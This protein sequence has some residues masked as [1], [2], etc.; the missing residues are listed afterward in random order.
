MDVLTRERAK[1]ALPFAGAYQ[2]LDFPLSNLAHSGITD[3]WLSVQYHASTLEEQAANGRPWDLD[4]TRGGL[5]LLVPQ[6]GTG[7][8]DEEGFARGNADL[9][10]RIRDEITA[11]GPDVLLVLSA[12]HVYRYDYNDLLDAHAGAGATCT[13]LTTE[14]PL[15]EASNHAVVEVDA[16]GRVTAFADKPADPSSGVVATEVFAYRPDA[17]VATLEDL[18]RELSAT[19]DGPEHDTGLGD[20]G[21]VLLPRLVDQGEVAARAFSG[22]WRD[23]GQPHLY[24]RAH[25][26]VLTDDLDV[27]GDPDWPILTRARHDAPARVLAGGVVADSLL[28]AGSRVSGTVER[29]VLGAGV[30]VA[31]GAVIR[32][33]VIFAGTI[34]ESGARVDGSIVDR[35][36]V[37][38]AGATLGEPGRDAS[39]DP[40]SVVLVGRGSTVAADARIA[41]GARLE[42]GTS[43]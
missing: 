5:R 4:R 6:E 12:D 42:P 34:V 9:L 8:L 37:V 3:V 29:S 43:A 14:V 10:F 35:D 18:H 2:L 24:L 15:A 20:F 1:P 23:L 17:L 22:Y 32:D 7:G 26:D 13:M 33:S 31:A 27:F 36:C 21:D 25:A 40:D 19:A 28:T 38:G 11:F 39:A 30:V 16:A 41:G